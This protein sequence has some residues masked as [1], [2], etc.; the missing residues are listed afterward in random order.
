MKIKIVELFNVIINNLKGDIKEKL[1]NYLYASVC[2]C[3]KFS[4]E[5]YV[6]SFSVFPLLFE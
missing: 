2:V 5:I 1:W 4:V 6:E 3:G